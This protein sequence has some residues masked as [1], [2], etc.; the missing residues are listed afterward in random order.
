[1]SLITVGSLLYGIVSTGEQHSLQQAEIFRQIIH[2][3]D[4]RLIAVHGSS[5]RSMK[6]FG[7][8]TVIVVP[9]SS[10]VSIEISPFWV[11]AASKAE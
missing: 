5:F 9:F 3:E 1:M 4:F 8:R 6:V 11:R 2:A 10:E 7:K